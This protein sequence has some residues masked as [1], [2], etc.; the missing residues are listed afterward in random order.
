MREAGRPEDQGGEA[1]GVPAQAVRR[2][3]VDGEN[4]HGR[5][6]DLGTAAAEEEPL[7][8]LRRVEDE[9][10]PG[11]PQDE[12]AGQSEEGAAALLECGRGHPRPE[13]RDHE[14]DERALRLPDARDEQEGALQ[15]SLARRSGHDR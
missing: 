5:E 15:A 8:P 11:F 14:V 10:R 6:R 13:P 7:V 2:R 12:A 9:G 1:P 3:R 4:E